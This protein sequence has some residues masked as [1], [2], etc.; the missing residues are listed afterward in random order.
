MAKL[1]ALILNALSEGYP[2]LLVG[3]VKQAI[4]RWRNSDWNI[5]ASQVQ[6]DF[7]NFQPKE[8]S[9]EKNWRSRLK[10]IDFNN[11]VI[12]AVLQSFEDRLINQ[13]EDNRLLMKFRS[14][15]QDYIQKP[16]NPSAKT[17]GY[18]EIQFSQGRF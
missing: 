12:G 8:I 9:L 18:A 13:L 11:H 3:D 17:D 1:Q 10:I 4:Y 6:S 7:P 16:G 15:Y 2:T 5:L 14:V